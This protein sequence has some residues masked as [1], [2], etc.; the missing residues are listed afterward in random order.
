MTTNILLAIF[1]YFMIPETRSIALE[2]IDVLFGG[3]NHTEKGGDL[4]N[5][6]DAH[7]A[8]IGVDNVA[9]I[10]DDKISPAVHHQQVDAKELNM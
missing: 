10:H 8:H 6:E 3:A 1:V 4:L 2:E 5:V 9:G 7:H